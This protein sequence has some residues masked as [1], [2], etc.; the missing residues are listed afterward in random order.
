ML[1]MSRARSRV[2]HIVDT[3]G[4]Q[5]NCPTCSWSERSMHFRLP[6]QYYT[7]YMPDKV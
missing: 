7:Q 1:V 3:S 2:I 6:K 5:I 4:H